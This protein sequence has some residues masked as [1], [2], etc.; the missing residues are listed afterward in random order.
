MKNVV[1]PDYNV[2]PKGL[3]VFPFPTGFR[4]IQVL[5]FLMKYIAQYIPRV[6]V[7]Q[8]TGDFVSFHLAFTSS[9]SLL[10]SLHI[11]SA[12]MLKSF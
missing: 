5:N 2:V 12:V 9:S 1:K 10:H 4:L 7:T 11:S 3:I 8:I 6:F